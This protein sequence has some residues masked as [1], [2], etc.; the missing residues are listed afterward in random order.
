MKA[1]TVLE[2]TQRQ[3]ANTLEYTRILHETL[4]KTEHKRDKYKAALEEIVK[5][6]DDSLYDDNPAVDMYNTAK[7]ALK[8]D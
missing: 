2:T 7:E 8:K 5:I 3:L 4:R 1:L 6:M